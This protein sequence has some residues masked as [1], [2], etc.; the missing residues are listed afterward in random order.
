MIKLNIIY[1]EDSDASKALLADFFIDPTSISGVHGHPNGSVVLP[2]N[3]VV[4]ETCKEVMALI[5]ETGAE[6]VRDLQEKRQEE[7]MR[8]TQTILGKLTEGDI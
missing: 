7:G 2:Y 6:A 1:H 5:S 3:K 4:K 8:M